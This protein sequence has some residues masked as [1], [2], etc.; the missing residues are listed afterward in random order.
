M[1]GN[2]L[3][4]TWKVWKQI[5]SGVSTSCFLNPARWNISNRIFISRETCTACFRFVQTTGQYEHCSGFYSFEE[6]E[7][8]PLVWR[9]ESN[10]DVKWLLYLLSRKMTFPVWFFWN[11]Q[12]TQLLFCAPIKKKMFEW[13]SKTF[14]QL[15]YNLWRCTSRDRPLYWSLVILG[16][17]LVLSSILIQEAGKYLMML[18]A[19]CWSNQEWNEE[20]NKHWGGWRNFT[21]AESS[22]TGNNNWNGFNGDIRGV[23]LFIAI[24]VLFCIL[25]YLFYALGAVC[26]YCRY[27]LCCRAS[28]TLTQSVQVSR[29]AVVRSR[30]SCPT[31]AFVALLAYVL[32]RMLE[33]V[34]DC[35]R[36]SVELRRRA[37]QMEQRAYA[38]QLEALMPGNKGPQ[39][40][41]MRYTADWVCLLYSRPYS[42]GRIKRFS[43][44]VL[45]WKTISNRPFEIH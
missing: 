24:L 18:P 16:L 42:S 4:Q 22:S 7:Y 19:M 29:W 10:L 38:T 5:A 32:H 41:V 25:I 30:F 1:C 15:C 2:I 33:Q 9:C 37:H 21:S 39:S 20:W 28:A 13:L 14:D 36:H 6:Q 26:C 12:Y 34:Q 11:M 45:L 31:L 27:R 8:S 17:P 23:L 40:V 3:W 44:W 43:E 35:L